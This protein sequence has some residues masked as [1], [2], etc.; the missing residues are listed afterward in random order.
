MQ[1]HLEG[2][3]AQIRSAITALNNLLYKVMEQKLTNISIPY[4]ILVGFSSVTDVD[5][6]CEHL[7]HAVQHNIYVGS[8]RYK[9]FRTLLSAPNRAANRSKMI[10]L[11]GAFVK[12]SE[13]RKSAREYD[14]DTC[15]KF[16]NEI[17]DASNILSQ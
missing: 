7:S 2:E 12:G 3:K 15:I 4:D 16:L 11:L 6:F 14:L 8:E 1:A 10:D 17:S 5:D 9:E 13:G